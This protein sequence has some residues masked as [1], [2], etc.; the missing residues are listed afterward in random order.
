MI[1]YAVCVYRRDVYESV[2]RPALRRQVERFGAQIVEVTTDTGLGEAYERA[3]Q[4]AEHETIVYLH[5]D[6]ELLDAD[7]TWR[8]GMLLGS[9]GAGLM[10]VVGSSAKGDGTAPWWDDSL[11]VGS[12]VRVHGHDRRVFQWYDGRAA[13]AVAYESQRNPDAPYAEA[14]LLD[15]LILCDRTG[16]SWDGC[17]QG[18]HGYD[19]WRSMQAQA[20]GHRVVV[21]DLSVA[22]WNQPHTAQWRDAVE[23]AMQAARERW[24]L[25]EPLRRRR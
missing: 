20:A 11:K 13:R 22:H 23:P 24:G 2:C 15:G 7:A 10:G 1:T 4:A 18:F 19:I 9:S 8:I 14:R 3:R 17:P 16:L 12:W 6:V 21:G 5:D 25:K